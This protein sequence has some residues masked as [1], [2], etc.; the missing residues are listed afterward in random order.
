[1]A[2]Q[3]KDTNERDDSVEHI[4]MND[5][6]KPEPTEQD[7]GVDTVDASSHDDAVNGDEADHAA[8]PIVSDHRGT[9][10]RLWGW[11]TSH[12]K[13]AIPAAVVLLVAF[14]AAIPVTR[15]AIAGTFLKQNFQITVIDESTSKPVTSASVSLKGKQAQTNNQGKAT[16][17]VPVGSG[18]LKIVKKYYKTITQNVTVPLNK[19]AP[20]QVKI[21]A[22]GRQVPVSVIN[23]V[24]GKAIENASITAED[25]TVKTDAKGEAIIVLP[26]NKT[27]VKA[28]LTGDGY[29]KADVT[30][31]VTAQA[32]KANTFSLTPSG[33]VYFLSNAS[34]KIDV[35]KSD[36][37]G[38][39]RST[40]LAGTGKEDKA[41]TVLLASQDWK[42]LALLSKRDGGDDAKL[43]LIDTSN[44]A[45][46][47]MDEGQANF[48]LTGWNGH[49]FVYQVDRYK[50]QD[51]ESK[52]QALK[53]FNADAKKLATLDETTAAGAQ[54]DYFREYFST[55]FILDN[56]IVY[57][58]NF[59]NWPQKQAVGRKA[60]INT[61]KPDGSGKRELKSWSGG[62]TYPGQ[63]NIN[64]TVV[65]YGVNEVYF[66]SSSDSNYLYEYEDGQVKTVPNKLAKDIYGSEYFTYLFSPSN[67][68]TFWSEPR[69]GKNTLFVGDAA[70]ENSKQVASASEYQTFGWFTE[71]YL[72]LSKKGSEL[73]IMPASGL[74][75]GSEPLKLTDY[76]KPSLSY[77]GYGKGYGGF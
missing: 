7:A 49:T 45:L 4:D 31:K 14:L 11:I 17:R 57:A 10:H 69:D 68:A 34:G 46:S 21:T 64:I 37:D 59:Y 27:E 33:K 38:Q 66:A 26:A 6:T 40:V 23:K 77:P 53:S 42:Y 24:S 9:H 20:L 16:L 30:I 15:Y 48:T 54:N 1:M 75:A 28:I 44:D 56:E 72:L 74:D 73:Y 18:E 65:P 55:A 61:V 60:T 47:V 22:T 58:K 39:N 8:T 62:D 36:L 13:I 52:R 35:I 71:N 29:N 32:D 25:A 51:W 5:E 19:P 70:G 3:E 2:K 50:K 63:S 12:K 43:F 41:N 67:K 76:Y